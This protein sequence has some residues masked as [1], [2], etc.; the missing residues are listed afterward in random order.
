MR[1]ITV[2]GAIRDE[3][4]G[5]IPKDIDL[6]ATQTNEAKLLAAGYKKI[7]AK[8]HMLFKMPTGEEV[9]LPVDRQT[10]QKASIEKDLMSR[11]LTINAIG[12]DS[13]DAVFIDPSNGRADVE[14]KVFRALPFFGKDPLRLFR[15][16]RFHAEYPEFTATEETLELCRHMFSQNRHFMLPAERVAAELIKALKT[17]HPSRF[18]E[19]LREVGGLRFWF[20]EVAAMIDVPQTPEHHPEGNVW[21][22]TMIAMDWAAQ[23]PMP[24]KTRQDKIDTGTKDSRWMTV[25]MVLCHDFGKAVTPVE[26]LPSHPCHDIVGVP[27]ARQFCSRLKMPKGLTA[28]TIW[29]CENHTRVHG[30]FAMGAS[31]LV[32]L[33]GDMAAPGLIVN[34]LPLAGAADA[35]SRSAKAEAVGYPNYNYISVM[36]AHYHTVMVRDLTVKKLNDKDEL[37]EV[38]LANCSPEQIQQVLLQRRVGVIKE[39]MRRWKKVNKSESAGKM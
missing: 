33:L 15:L 34:A 11:D 10:N 9:S 18:F 31:R 32:K 17:E 23:Y 8:N 6:V 38:P 2:G 5:L 1:L 25:F 19:F 39:H 30:V 7:D 27:L 35:M 22:H 14:A 24:S 29:N 28:T 3:L 20:D 4:L 13:V 12:Y 26:D 21:E 37:I 36:Y 16:A